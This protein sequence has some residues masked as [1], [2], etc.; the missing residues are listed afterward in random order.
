MRDKLVGIH[1][2]ISYPTSI[3]NLFDDQEQW[4]LSPFSNLTN[5][6]GTSLI[7]PASPI[8]IADER[9][10]ISARDE[11][12]MSRNDRSHRSNREA[13]PRR[14]FPL[15][16]LAT[17]S[18]FPELKRP[19]F[20]PRPGGLSLR[21]ETNDNKCRTSTRLV[22]LSLSSSNS[23]ITKKRPS[24]DGNSGSC[25]SPTV[26]QAVPL[27]EM[28]ALVQ[29]GAAGG[30]SKAGHVVHQVPSAHHQLRGG[31][32]RSASGTSRD[33]E[34]PGNRVSGEIHR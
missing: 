6:I 12:L 5:S 32:A 10:L 22:F 28:I 9:G 29:R 34:Q 15:R 3:R 30:T 19:D 18:R 31:D 2:Y 21:G 13:A 4:T 16:E 26:D 17:R 20:R 11:R 1:V 27:P 24:E 23:L 33:G 7:C 25:L 8:E 14:L